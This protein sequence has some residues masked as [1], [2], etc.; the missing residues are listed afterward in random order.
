MKRVLK[1]A[2]DEDVVYYSDFNG[3]L[4]S[5]GVINYPPCEVAICFNYGSSFDGEQFTLHL[6][7]E[8]ALE[9]RDFL[10]TKLNSETKNELKEISFLD[11]T[12][13]VE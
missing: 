10:K 12:R 4:L 1:P 9:L 7:D 8:E 6:S 13:E 2:Q 11:I 3:T 5:D